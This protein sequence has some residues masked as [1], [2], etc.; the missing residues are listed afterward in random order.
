M[1]V[2]GMSGRYGLSILVV[3]EAGSMAGRYATPCWTFAGL[4]SAAGDAAV[5]GSIDGVN[6]TEGSVDGATD[7]SAAGNAASEAGAGDADCVDRPA[8]RV[9]ATSTD[10]LPV[11]RTGAR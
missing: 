5:D 2:P 4:P 9:S 10:A 11:S 3:N 1:A 6:D 7:G 8:H